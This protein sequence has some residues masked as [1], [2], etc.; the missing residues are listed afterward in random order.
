[1]RRE[2]D[3]TVREALEA[4]GSS[5]DLAAAALEKGNYKGVSWHDRCPIGYYLRDYLLEKTGEVFAV[6]V[7]SNQV[8]VDRVAPGQDWETVA[9]VAFIGVDH[10]ISNFIIRF[11]AGDYPH[12]QKEG[13]NHVP[14]V[15]T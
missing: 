12:L 5:A 8:T 9:Y 4:L 2:L 3:G 11:D 13:L 1:M 6:S 7:Y 14:P 15:R 10:P